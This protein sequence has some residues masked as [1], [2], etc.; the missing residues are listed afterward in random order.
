MS[1]IAIATAKPTAKVAQSGAG[2]TSIKPKKTAVKK[3]TVLKQCVGLDIAKNDIQLCFRE[4]LS[5]GTLRIRVQKKVNNTITGWKNIVIAIDKYRV[6]AAP[7]GLTVVMEA[8][9]VY[10][11]NVC[12]YLHKQ[13][14]TL[15]V[16]LPNK[17]KSYA[18]SLGLKSKTDKIDGQLLAQM[19][20]ERTLEIWV[21]PSDNTLKMKQLA[22]E[23]QMLIDERTSVTNQLHALNHAYGTDTAITKRFDVRL[24]LLSKQMKEV[25]QS[26][27]NLV[28]ADPELKVKTDR[29]CTIKGFGFTTAVVLLSETNAFDTFENRAQLTSYAG[30]DV[31]ENASG[32]HVGKT[33]ISKHGN[34]HI[35]AALYF[36]SMTAIRHNPEMKELY[37]RVFETT[38]IKMKALVAVQRKM[39]LLAFALCKNETDF[40]PEY[41]AKQAQIKTQATDEATKKAEI[42]STIN[43]QN[44]INKKVDTAKDS[45]YAA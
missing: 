12:Y 9:G 22:R 40:D 31:V 39:L 13:G 20:L 29:I 6:K 3:A 2:K 32:N 24:K 41:R 34:S 37:D 21:A 30:Y 1:K 8:T 27:V 23:R 7:N 11:E 25:E 42:S 4:Q 45:T 16:I 36:P 17:S 10:H 5:D 14:Y 19:G 38:K 28:Q 35:R 18:K 43:Q 15:S 33:R 44:T 26:L